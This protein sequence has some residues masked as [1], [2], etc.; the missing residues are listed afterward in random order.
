MGVRAE[1]RQEHVPAKAAI[2]VAVAIVRRGDGRVLMAE[3]LPRQL[4]A[5]YWELPGGKVDPGESPLSAAAREAE[6]EVGVRIEALRPLTQYEHVFPL[7]RLRLHFFEAERWQGQPAGRE[8]QRIA[9][10]DPADPDVGPVLPSNLRTLALLGLPSRMV[11]LSWPD[12]MATGAGGDA[13]ICVAQRRAGL[14]IHQRSGTRSMFEQRLRV[15]MTRARAAGA[16]IWVEDDLDTALRI[17]AAGLLTRRSADGWLTRP[18]V[19]LW[20]VTC[21][22]LTE[23]ERFRWLGADV[24]VFPAAQWSDTALASAARLL[25]AAYVEVPPGAEIDA[26]Q[27]RCK[28]LGLR[29]VIQAASHRG[30]SC[31]H[32]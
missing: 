8:G 21:R 22:D 26:A 24:G 6:E 10:V 32:Y 2:D 25:P 11:R 18:A 29:G 15:D 16:C 5:G 9:W 13:S 17:D 28:Q 12:Q 1:R 20:A 3:R 31:H 19:P 4:S 30:C 14:I 7:R 27:M 23:V